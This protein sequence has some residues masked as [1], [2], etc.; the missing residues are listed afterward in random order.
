MNASERD[1]LLG[2]LDERTEH[3][4]KAVEEHNGQ[5]RDLQTWQARMMGGSAVVGVIVVVAQEDVREFV[6]KVLGG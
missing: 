1:E 2:R 3:I 5:I 4:K 6:S